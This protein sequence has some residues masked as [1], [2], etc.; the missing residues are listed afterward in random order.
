MKE[1]YKILKYSFSDILRSRWLYIYTLLFLAISF[2][3]LYI[4]GDFGKIL[5]S[6]S[7][8]VLYI[9]P[10]VAIIYTSIYYYNSL[11]FIQLLLTM[12]VRRSNIITGI[13]LGISS[14]LS[15][16]V[17][18]GINLPFLFNLS[19]IESASSLIL[20]NLSAVALTFI[21]VGLAL[22]LVVL[23][24]NKIKG[25]GF[26]L[27]T[28]FLLVVLYDMMILLI[29]VVFKSYPIEQAVLFTTIAN[30][31]D[32]TRVM[33]TLNFENA[34]VLGYTGAVFQKFF[35]TNQGLFISAFLVLFWITL[36]YL[37]FQRLFFKKDF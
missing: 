26:S 13:F 7:N 11:S 10:L 6:L 37:V 25:F 14:S 21:F 30:P 23:N 4:D 34:A 9:T 18:I 24:D 3:L 17:I 16:G 12:P 32:L 20:L 33:I 2:G 35:G 29:I 1:I 28:W 31:V 15:I 36:P 8:L 19:I 27:L 5:I 22:W